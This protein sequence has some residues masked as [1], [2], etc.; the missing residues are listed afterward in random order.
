MN[1]VERIEEYLE[2]REKDIEAAIEQLRANLLAHQGALSLIKE[3]REKLQEVK[4]NESNGDYR[5]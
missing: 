1:E 4:E 2:E 5:E 3:I